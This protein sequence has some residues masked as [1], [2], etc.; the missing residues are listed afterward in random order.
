MKIDRLCQN[1]HYRNP[2]THKMSPWMRKVFIEV[3][4]YYLL[5]RRPPQ[6][7][8]KP[9]GADQASKGSSSS[10]MVRTQCQCHYLPAAMPFPNSVDAF[11]GAQTAK[12]AG[13][14]V[15]VGLPAPVPAG[16][17]NPMIPARMEC[18]NADAL[19]SPSSTFQMDFHPSPS[20]PAAIQRIAAGGRDSQTFRA[21]G[22][23]DSFHREQS[24]LRSAVDSVTFIAEH[25]RREEEDQQVGHCPLTF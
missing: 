22:S 18:A 2:S 16:P 15:P 6:K 1:V 8:K 20:S 7:G 9:P 25:F 23:R 24:P 11:R 5:M 14:P 21:S 10:I 12:R 19:P 3:L 13:K 17:G 4:P